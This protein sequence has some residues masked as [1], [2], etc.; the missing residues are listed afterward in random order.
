[1]IRTASWTPSMSSTIDLL[2]LED[3]VILEEAPD[4]AQHVL[5]QLALVGVVGER[6][7][8]DADRDDLVVDAL[9]VAHP[10]HPDGAGFD[11][12]QRM[13]RLLPQHQRVERI[14]VIA[15]R[16]RDEAVIGRIV[17]GAVE[18]AI[19]PQQA[20]LLV[21]LVLVLAA[22]RD[23]DDDRKRGLDQ[24]VVDIAVVPGMHASSVH[25]Q[26]F[27]ITGS[28]RPSQRNS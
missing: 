17:D 6:G 14:A 24:G 25:G 28:G 27:R 10:H 26:S 16:A 23:F 18:H 21:E 13:H 22:V 1:M 20:R 9:L 2:L 7:I 15:E 5:R 4:L 11:D 12:R 8:A 19:E 3:L